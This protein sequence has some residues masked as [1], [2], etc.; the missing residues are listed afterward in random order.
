MAQV[1][2]H[3][4][5]HLMIDEI[6]DHITTKEEIQSA[7]G[8]YKTKYGFDRKKRTTKGWQF[9]AKWKDGYGEWVAMKDLKYSYPI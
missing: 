5:R 9:Y 1:D 4:N 6:E 3:G 2:D 7:Q 8:N